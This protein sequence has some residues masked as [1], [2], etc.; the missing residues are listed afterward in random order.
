MQAAINYRDINYMQQQNTNKAYNKNSISTSYLGNIV[1]DSETAKQALVSLFNGQDTL[2]FTRTK[3]AEELAQVP[4]L[5]RLIAIHDKHS[6]SF[7][8]KTVT[9]RETGKCL[10]LDKYLAAIGE[11]CKEQALAACS[12]TVTLVLSVNPWFLLGCSV[13]AGGRQLDS[14][15]HYPGGDYASGPVS[16]ALDEC[17]VC[18]AV[19]EDTGLTGRML[20]HVDAENA[21]IVTS[22]LYGDFSE[23]DSSFIRKELYKLF[24][25]YKVKDWKKTGDYRFNGNGFSG[26]TDDSHYQ[27]YRAQHEQTLALKLCSPVCP[28]CGEEHSEQELTCCSGRY[29]CD[30]CGERLHED[31]MYGNDN[32]TYC[33]ECFYEKYF[34]CSNCEETHDKSDACDCGTR[35]TLC[36]DC[37]ERKGY[38]KCSDCGEYTEDYTCMNDELYCSDCLPDGEYCEHCGEYTAQEDITTT[39]EDKHYC[40]DCLEDYSTRCHSCGEHTDSTSETIEGYELCSDCSDKLTAC[41]CCGAISL[42]NNLLACNPV[43]SSECATNNL[44]NGSNY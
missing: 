36:S 40:S 43:C 29:T 32:G 22:R 18:A 9:E 8:S 24:L 39:Q 21:G 3:S 17:T 11:D 10:Q 12:E 35:G 13:E 14:S 20:I 16:Y 30:C 33:Q 34:Y 5:R 42:D 37:A 26:Y 7:V 38:Y 1:E 19:W 41:T 28:E 6:F 31:Y 27:G 4:V 44:F 15:C 2:C 25:D 23:T